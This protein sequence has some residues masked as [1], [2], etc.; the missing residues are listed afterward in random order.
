MLSL[1]IY[2]IFL[3]KKILIEY[4]S[5]SIYYNHYLLHRRICM[6]I[7]ITFSYHFF[8]AY[9]ERKYMYNICPF[10]LLLQKKRRYTDVRFD[11][12]LYLSMNCMFVTIRTEF[13]QF[14]STGCVVS[15]LLSNISGNT[16]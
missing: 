9:N 1:F 7:T 16:P 8:Y 6:F 15:I 3:L 5:I 12:F 4:N 14:Q 13:S 10:V 2:L 11:L